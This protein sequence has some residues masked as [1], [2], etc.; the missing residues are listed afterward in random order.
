MTHT[1]YRKEHRTMRNRTSILTAATLALVTAVT[2]GTFASPHAAPAT[3]ADAPITYAVAGDSLSAMDNSWMHQ[4]DDP[5]LQYAGGFQRS[6]YTTNGVYANI[7]PGTADVLVVMLGTNDIRYGFDAAHITSRIEDIVEKFGGAGHVLIA[8][9][10]PN[11]YTDDNGINR[12]TQSIIVNRAFVALAAKHGWMYAD[13]WSF[14]RGWDNAWG[15]GAS[16]DR[17]H[18]STLVAGQAAGRMDVYIRQA[19]VAGN[20][21]KTSQ[22]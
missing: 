6:G 4:L 3:A 9:T 5:E 16:P 12:R 22:P 2:V 21:G 11:D 18:P 10:P 20:I 7:T 17:T 8:F 13:P 19:A 14:Q 15:S 1:P